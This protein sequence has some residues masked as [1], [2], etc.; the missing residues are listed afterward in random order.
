MQK[1][2]DTPTPSGKGK[3]TTYPTGTPK[4]VGDDFLGPKGSD[5]SGIVK[6][7]YDWFGGFFDKEDSSN[8]YSYYK[9]NNSVD[10]YYGDIT[11]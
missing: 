9:G 1:D 8:N 6:S 4:I 10:Y 7:F 11:Y 2:D 3:Q 5:K